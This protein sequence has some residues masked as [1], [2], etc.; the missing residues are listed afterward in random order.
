MSAA[1]RSSMCLALALASATAVAQLERVSSADATSALRA[2]LEKGSDA[3]VGAL[4]RPDGFLGNAQVRIPLPESAGRAEKMMRR[5][6]AGKYAD[7][8]IVTMNRA[9]ESAVPEAKALFVQSVKNMTVQDAKRIITGGDTAG[10]DYFRR[11]TR[12]QLH[13]RFLPIVEQATARLQL[14]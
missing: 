13:K 3:A 4:G 14:A 12:D 1:L 11:T 10:T 7:E 5:F 9:A 6:G 8:L 2:A